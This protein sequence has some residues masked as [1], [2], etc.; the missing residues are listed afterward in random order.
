MPEPLTQS[1]LAA[2]QPTLRYHQR[3]LDPI[4]ELES[5]EVLRSF[6]VK[7]DEIGARTDNAELLLHA[8]GLLIQTGADL[9]SDNV[10]DLVRL[11]LAAV[12]PREIELSVFY[13]FVLPLELASYDDARKEALARLWAGS[14]TSLGGYDFALLVDGRRPGVT[15]HCEFGIVSEEEIGFRL[16]RM[17][18][19]FVEYHGFSGDLPEELP[20]VAFFADSRWHVPEREFQGDVDSL[21]EIVRSVRQEADQIIGDI[22]ARLCIGK[23]GQT[24]AE[25]SP[26]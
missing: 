1:L 7:T 11:A 25:G 19:H 16:K 2:W 10:F 5:R 9:L 18:G 4:E 23:E 24:M 8:N 12:E 3:R 13:Q 14:F 20:S 6:R 17:V 21:A 15:W 26:R 22:H